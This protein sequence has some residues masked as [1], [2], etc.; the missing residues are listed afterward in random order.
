M[1]IASGLGTVDVVGDPNAPLPV[2][3][4]RVFNDGG[5][6][7]T[8]GLT[9]EA[10]KD[11]DALHQGDTGVLIA[12]ADVVKFRLNIGV[13]TLTDGANVTFTVRDKDGLVVKTV[14]NKSFDPTIFTQQPSGQM[15][16]G[17]AITGGETISV[18]V[19]S[20]SLF[21][22]GATTDNVT[23]DPSVQFAKKLE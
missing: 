5:A 3:L 23:Q 15:L 6:A 7:G 1:G 2:A 10:F 22:Y 9:E 16:D 11:T 8:S 21:I 20:G 19:N 12:P 14:S 13:R 4:V 17:Y 18:T